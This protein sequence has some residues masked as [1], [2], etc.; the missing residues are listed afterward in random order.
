MQATS[1][2]N[3][4]IYNAVRETVR[5]VLKINNVTVYKVFCDK[6]TSKQTCNISGRHCKVH[7][8]C[9]STEMLQVL[10]KALLKYNCNAV[11]QYSALYNNFTYI[12]IL[13]L[14]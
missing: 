6:R 3:Q 9:V 2:K 10:R 7:V 1:A 12:K 4:E 11:V 5:E 8:K 13:R 14:Q